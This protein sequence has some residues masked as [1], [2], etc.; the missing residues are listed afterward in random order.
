V[1][2]EDAAGMLFCLQREG[3]YVCCEVD[4]GE[5]ADAVECELS[6]Y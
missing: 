2:G 5:V 4:V 3:E 6:L 1:F